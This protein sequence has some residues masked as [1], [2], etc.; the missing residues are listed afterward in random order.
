[1]FIIL[2]GISYIR[3]LFK[4]SFFIAFLLSATLANAKIHEFETTHLKSLAGTGVAGIFMEEAAFL[5]PASLAYFNNGSVYAQRNT[6][7]FKNTQG[8]VTDESKATAFVFADGNPNVSGSLSYVDQEE[9]VFK[10]KRWG[11]SVSAPLNKESSLGVSTRKST[12][13]NSL[14]QTKDD[15]YQTVVGVTHSLD[16][17]T[18]FGVVF[19]DVL[20]S[21]AKETKAMVG[22]QHMFA[23]TATLNFDLSAN[24][25]AEE[26]T[27]TVM[28]RGGLQFK[29]LDDFYLRFGA[30]NDKSKQ[31][32][33]NGYG[34]A[35]IQPRLAFEFAIKSTNAKADLALA[36]SERKLKETSLSASFRF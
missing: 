25:K 10:R 14:L 35:W 29:V 3:N 17:Q 1:M 34:I 5:N 32:K 22:A 31:E 6:H 30:F 16:S 24:Y 7:K 11:L 15:Y 21:K 2:K 19:Y 9:G 20:N 12:D 33:G 23:N 18:S 28:Y 8:L 27:D 26:I 13:E 36:R 4:K